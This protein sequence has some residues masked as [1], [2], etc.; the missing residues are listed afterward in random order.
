M[1]Y[2]IQQ[3]YVTF[4]SPGTMVAETDSKKV[5]A[6][7]VDQAVEMARSVE[8]R[9][10]ARPYGFCFS[11]RARGDADL[12]AKETARGPMYYLGGEVETI[13]EI[14]ARGDPSERILLANMRC[15]GWNRVVV[16]TNSYRWIQPLKD[17]DVVLDVKL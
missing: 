15:N 17:D 14:E 13:E 5:D 8:Q 16:N 4:Y 10:G 11:T 3:H 2:A 1:A 9:H 12:D 7:D 6:W